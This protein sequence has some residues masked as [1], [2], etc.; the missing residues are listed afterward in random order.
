MIDHV[1]DTE[2]EPSIYIGDD[3]AMIC[4]MLRND[5]PDTPGE[6]HPVFVYDRESAIMDSRYGSVFV[7]LVSSGK[8]I[9]DTDYRTV[10]RMPRLAVKLSCR[11]RDL[12][13]RWGRIIESILQ[14]RRRGMRCISPYTFLEITNERPDNSS[15]GWYSYTF[16][17]KLTGFHIPVRSSGFKPYGGL[18]MHDSYQEAP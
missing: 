8:S 2:S 4:D 17:I 12:M 15:D 11:S 1:Y 16:D 18:E 5:W 3:A 6:P 7:Y 9:A 14:S 10:D 13:F